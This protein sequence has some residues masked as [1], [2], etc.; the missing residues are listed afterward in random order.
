[1]TL[2]KYLDLE[3]AFGL[4]SHGRMAARGLHAC[5]YSAKPMDRFLSLSAIRATLYPSSEATEGQ[6]SG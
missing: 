2:V 4:A 3:P 5:S 6:P 1:M